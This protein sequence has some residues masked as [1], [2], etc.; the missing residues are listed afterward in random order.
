MVFRCRQL[1]IESKTWLNAR[2]SMSAGQGLER[3]GARSNYSMN[4]RAYKPDPKRGR[5]TE[6]TSQQSATWRDYYEMCKPRVVMLMILTSVVGMLLAVPGMVP[7]DV[8][9]Y[10]DWGEGGQP[11]N[12]YAVIWVEADEEEK[13]EGAE[14]RLYAGIPELFDAVVH[15][16]LGLPAG[17]LR[18][19]T[20]P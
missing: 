11:A 14:V 15:R 2:R 12:R 19:K 7:L 8:A 18:S 1:E 4:S 6:I 17:L 13:V 5:V 16:R 3:L 20:R 9:G 10:I